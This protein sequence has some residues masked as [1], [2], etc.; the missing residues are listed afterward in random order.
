MLS[1][2][3]IEY[4]TSSAPSTGFS[5]QEVY[6]ASCHHGK[7]KSQILPDKAKRFIQRITRENSSGFRRDENAKTSV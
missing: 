5:P 7:K 3:P 1:E 2:V 4:R 6:T